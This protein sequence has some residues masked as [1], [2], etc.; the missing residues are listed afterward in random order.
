MKNVF[1][2]LV[3][4]LTNHVFGQT[5]DA[6][7]LNP[8]QIA[9]GD[10]KF[11]R[12]G[13]SSNYYA[14]FMWNEGSNYYGNGDD[15]SIF[16]YGDRDVTIRTGMGNF[17]VFPQSGGNMGIGTTAPSEKLE[18]RST[19]RINN[20]LTRGNSSLKIDRG[21]DGKD[22]AVVSYG[23]NS[24]YVWHTGLLY[25]GGSPT[26][27]FYISQ[28]QM[29]HDGNANIVHY[30][31][32]TIKTNGNIGIG[33]RYPDSKLAVKGNIH[34]EEVKVDLSVPAPDY[35]FKND[36]DLKPIEE[37]QDFI[38]RNG[39]LYNIPNA[40]AMEE[41]GIEL[42]VMNMKLLE[43]IEELTL[44]L[45][46][47]NELLKLEARKNKQQEIQIKQLVFDIAEIRKNE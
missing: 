36:Y 24:N 22:V 6:K 40:L 12:F 41:N 38:K 16:T 15:F 4:M 46:E 14:G 19:I 20:P 44:Y 23:Q 27:D 18:V 13:N 34:A 43:K 29:I 3:C 26:T 10:Y 5:L 31:E 28:N 45:I 39:H 42:G 30:P 32:L 9:P 35:V 21:S 25:N 37:V 11:L 7:Y 8:L 2:F 33:T 17:I 47:Q 1:V